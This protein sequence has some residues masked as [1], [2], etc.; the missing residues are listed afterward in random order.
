MFS[1]NLIKFSLFLAACVFF[2]ACGWRASGNSANA[3]ASFAAEPAKSGIPFATEEP[4]NFQAEFVITTNDAETKIFVARAGGDRS[5]YDFDAGEAVESTVLQRKAGENF[6]ILPREKIY[7]EDFHSQPASAP[8]DVSRDFL[9][10]E[11]LNQKPDAEFTRLETENNR[12]KY[13]VRLDASNASEA[14]VF[15]DEAI[16]LPVRQEFYTRRGEQKILTYAIEM[17]N[18]KAQA[19]ENLFEIPADARKVSIE[20]LR[21][22]RREMKSDGK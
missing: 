18:F 13:A 15:V 19:D 5:R 16:K 9:T 21:E 8:M 4:E 6:L 1:S 14:I 10:S 12:T 17:R 11:W 20:R 2:C 3:P 22:R 7:A